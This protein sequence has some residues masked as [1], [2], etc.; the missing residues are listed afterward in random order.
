M[1]VNDEIENDIFVTF[2][3]EEMLAYLVTVREHITLI[4]NGGHHQSV[5]IGTINSLMDQL[6]TV[7]GVP[8]PH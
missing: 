3:L 5:A 1:M 2:G 6:T 4:P 8:N 7:D